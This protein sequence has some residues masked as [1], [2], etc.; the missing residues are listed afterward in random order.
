MMFLLINFI[1]MIFKIEFC[2]DIDK[3]PFTR[4]RTNVNQDES[5]SG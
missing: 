3:A 5:S 4:D 2:I 1:I